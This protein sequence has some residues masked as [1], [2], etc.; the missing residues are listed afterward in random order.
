M[1][2]A[3]AAVSFWDLALALRGKP[4]QMALKLPHRLRL[5][6]NAL[7]ARKLRARWVAAAAL[8]LGVGVS[9]LELVCTGQVYLPL[10][11]YMTTVAGSRAR[12]LGLLLLYDLAFIA[13]LVVVFVAVYFGLTSE[14]LTEIFKR[15]MALGKLLLGGFFLALG[16]LLVQ[17]ELGA[18][19]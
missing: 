18:W 12:A 1:V 11:R 3:F 2:F 9:L 6:I 16:A 13:P 14:R 10:I 17:I 8:G 15:R 19:F 4:E 5:R 7:I